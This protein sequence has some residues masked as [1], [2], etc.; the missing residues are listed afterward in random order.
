[1]AQRQIKTGAIRG[2]AQ[3]AFVK[4]RLKQFREDFP[5]GKT[6]SDFYPDP[7]DPSITVFKCWVWKDKTD[8]IEIM[9]SG[10]TDKEILRSSADADG[11]AKSK[12]G[13]KEK[14]FE[15]LQT[16]ALGRALA[17]LGYLGSGEIASFEEMEEYDDWKNQQLQEYTDSQLEL[18]NKAKTLDELKSI[19]MANEHKEVKEL[20]EAKDKKKAELTKKEGKKDENK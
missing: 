7:K 15:K 3:Y 13:V 19:W 20:Q 6:E 17:M 8:L 4:D 16:I 9:K 2:G 12:V 18:I 5:K 10:T 1:M 11:A 14:D